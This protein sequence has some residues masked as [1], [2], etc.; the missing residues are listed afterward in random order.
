MRCLTFA[1]AVFF[2]VVLTAQDTGPGK[3]VFERTCAGC[4]GA[5]G[6]GGERGPAIVTRLSSRDDL[7]LAT[8]ILEGLPGTAMPPNQV[9]FA[10]MPALTRFLRSLQPRTQVR[11]LP[12]EKVQLTDGK[13][14]DGQVLNRGFDD[15]QLR[16]ADQEIHLLRQD[17]DRYREVTSQTDWPGYNGEPGGNRFTTVNQITKQNVG[18][19]APKW[20]F[21]QP[22]TAR[23][24]GTPVVANGVMY[25]TSANECY[26]LDAGTGRQIWHY[27]RPRTQGFVASA[28]NGN[29][30]GAALAGN[31]VFMVT[32]HAHIIALNA[33]SGELVWE[34]E[35]ADW[36][37]NYF[38]T[39]APLVVG[40]LV[41]SGIAG[42]ARRA[43]LRRGFRSG[44]GQGSPAFLDRSPAG[45]ARFGD[46]A[47]ERHRP[48]RS[49]HV[50]YRHLRCAA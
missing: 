33:S 20:V 45:R 41:V 6:N 48:W 3:I 12:T 4:H 5:D 24:Q 23:L 32:D 42:G 30:R 44:H 19:L 25:V 43:R 50:V 38:A 28:V 13:T 2:A 47:G 26:A 34:T 16:T 46:V 8:L 22:N 40:D 9:A 10:E 49:A 37:Q 29:N 31:R 7:Q 35:M 21:T 36:R 15:L 17:G 14:L 39:S 18:R 11:P 27:Q 1:S